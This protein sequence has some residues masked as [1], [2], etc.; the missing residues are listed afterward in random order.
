MD[1]ILD[2]NKTAEETSEEFRAMRAKHLAILSKY[3]SIAGIKSGRTPYVY[4]VDREAKRARA[5]A[6][7]REKREE[8]LAKTKEYR[9][10]HREYYLEKSREYQRRKKLERARDTKSDTGGVELH[11]G[12]ILES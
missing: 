6:R 7:Y 1:E 12:D 2:N 3:R 8:I 10:K 4:V 9:Q 11:S 5:R